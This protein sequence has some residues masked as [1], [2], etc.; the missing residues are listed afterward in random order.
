MNQTYLV[1]FEY[2]HDN[3]KCYQIIKGSVN[4]TWR[5]LQIKVDPRYRYNNLKFFYLGGEIILKA[6][7]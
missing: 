2:G 5:E 6:G 4:M 7:E 3:T 1:E